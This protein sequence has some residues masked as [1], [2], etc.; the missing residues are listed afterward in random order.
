MRGLLYVSIVMRGSIIM[1]RVLNANGVRQASIVLALDFTSVL[2]VM[3]AN[4]LLLEVKENT[5]ALIV[6]PASILLVVVAAV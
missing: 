6:P 2:I 4:I 5:S 1:L 3:P